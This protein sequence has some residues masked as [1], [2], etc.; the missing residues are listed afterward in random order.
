[1]PRHRTLTDTSIFGA[2][3]VIATLAGCGGAMSPAGSAS[4]PAVVQALNAHAP[5][6]PAIV[7]AD[8]GFGLTLFQNLLSQNLR[9]SPISNV[10]I[11]PVSVALALQLVYNGAA[12]TTQQAMTQTLQLGA[13]TTAQLNDDNA[14][15]EA[16]LI[17]SDP[18]VQIT[19]ANS[20]WM[21]LSDNPVLPSFIQTDQTY[22]GATLGD[23]AGAPDNINAWVTA[24]TQGLITQIAPRIDYTTIAAVIA[25]AIY[26][27]GAWSSAFD[28]SRTANGPFTLADGTQVSAPLMHQS[29]SFSYLQGSNF[30][31]I[32]LPYGQGHLSMLL[33]LPDSSI[34]LESFVSILDAQA[35]DSLVSPQQMAQGTIVLPRFTANYQQSLAHSLSSLGMGIA[36]C[37]S[38][39]AD[40][41]GI[42]SGS[43]SGVTTD[44]RACI[45]DV[46]HATVVE[47]DEHG[48]VAAGA[49][50]VSVGVTTLPTTTFTMTLDHPF[51]YAIRD[52]D[53]GALL[54]LGALMDPNA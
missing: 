31:A 2:L 13:R 50:V 35:L 4:P 29:G 21:H 53:S 41:S 25:N 11:A 30:Q 43:T 54:F 37:S 18:L 48:T 32:R 34:S 36:F 5:V 44:Q 19:L 14:A 1:M 33:V 3:F 16:S 42:I 23:L 39:A 49:T 9:L 7:S 24:E 10:A 52:D 46:L 22:Y 45:A 26:F 6:D 51:I 27:K 40:F 17:S 38:N 28:P 12:G 8:N 20:L 15:L 47:V